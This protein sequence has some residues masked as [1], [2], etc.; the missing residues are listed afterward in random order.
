MSIKEYNMDLGWKF[1]IN[2]DIK[3]EI[4]SHS[5]AYQSVKS[6]FASGA[7]GKEFADR[8]WETVDL[9][10]D[11]FTASDFDP[12]NSAAHGYRDRNNA[13]YR[14]SFVL[15]ETSA[16][17]ALILVFE[18]IAGKA[19]IYF[20]GFL[21]GKT[22]SSY[23]EYTFDI[24]DYAYCDERL[25][26]LAVHIDGSSYEGWW[27]EGAGIYRHVRL[28][29]KELTFIEHNG[30][31]AKPVL[32]PQTDND[33]IVELEVSVKNNSYKNIDVY[34]TA[35]IKF[36]GECV[37]N[38]K[39]ESV[40][41]V[42]GKDCIL[43]AD[44][45]VTNPERWDIESPNLYDVT[46]KL[47]N[48]SEILEEN[49]VR[50][51]FRTISVDADKGFFLNGR[52]VLIKGTCNHQ[53]HAGVGVAVSDSLHKWRVESLKRMGTNA[54]RCAHNMHAKEILDACDELG[55]IVMDENRHFQCDQ[56]ALSQLECLV[57]R[58]RN[59]PCVAF[60]SLFNEEP[61][62]STEDGAR[63][64]RRMKNLV[65]HLDDSRLITGAINGYI[66]GTALEMDIVGLNYIPFIADK[67][68]EKYPHLPI[69]GSENNSSVTTRGCYLSDRENL[70]VLNNY[71]EEIVAWGSTVRDMWRFVK[72]REYFAGI[73]I[74]TGF[75]YRGE[76]TPFVWP[77]VSSQFGIFDTC[78]FEKDLFYYNKACFV[79]EPLVHLLPHWTWK[80]GDNVR[81][82]AVTNCDEVEL[83]L[84]GKSLGKKEATVFD[85]PEWQVE[86]ESGVLS[87][88]AYRQGLCVAEDIQ[89][90]AKEPHSVILTSNYNSV[91]DSGQ[92][93]VLINAAV[94]DINGV[95]VPDAEN[96]IRFK[97]IGDGK[98]LGCGNGNPNSHENDVKPYRL[99]FHGLCQAVV[100]AN[101][102]ARE[103]KVIAESDGLLSGEIEIP[104]KKIQSP[105]YMRSVDGLFLGGF[106]T[107]DT[108]KER[109]D[110]TMEIADNDM[111]SFVPFMVP[112]NGY[113]GEFRNGWRIYRT[114][115]ILPVFKD[116]ANK[117]VLEFGEIRG[118]WVEIYI[119]DVKYVEKECFMGGELKVEFEG[120]SGKQAEIRILISAGE[121]HDCYG[122]SKFVKLYAK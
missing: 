37:A 80:K 25:N 99:A 8:D 33:W 26:V 58:D 81:V 101:E 45:D 19:E 85:P 67:A 22:E 76:P 72:E 88:K 6:G 42:A 120:E 18:G 29:E 52:K 39:T 10:H 66:E 53:D 14:K 115:P 110:P 28:F 3:K 48:G 40:V 17:K 113:Q 16:N 65:R 121:H 108:F 122:I 107:S 70:Q 46:V 112:P 21:I 83:I 11:Y 31:F 41:S 79:E 109:P 78:G 105:N 62:Q 60:W 51:G 15:E 95:V 43:N 96:L 102:K 90:T 57:K 75:D 93:T 100:R 34:A 87:A 35:E 2:N 30:I 119:N 111:N 74:W 20:N 63:I 91:N 32:K 61:L 4:K 55:M 44:I 71:D 114:R 12:D 13:W 1:Q 36:N 118:N 54:Y 38:G 94:V 86:F 97:V 98:V 69:I 59:H 27:Y 56:E 103:I 24:T 68:H 92:D 82:V 47:W 23:C 116:G 84:N 5:E 49:N 64:F 117:Y 77:S 7:A 50:I 89:Q 106:T 73:F 9:P 104:I